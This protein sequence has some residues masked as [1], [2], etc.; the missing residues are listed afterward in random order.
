M[1]AEDPQ[2]IKELAARQS[3]YTLVYG[4]SGFEYLPEQR[5]AYQEND[6]ADLAQAAGL[7][8]RP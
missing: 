1:I 4:V 7:R 8:S 5:V 6:L 3:P 2:E